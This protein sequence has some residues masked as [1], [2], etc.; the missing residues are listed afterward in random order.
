MSLAAAYLA[1][2]LKDLSRFKEPMNP[3]DM[4]EQEWMRLIRQSGLLSYYE[5]F[6]NAAQ[7]GTDAAFGPAVGT[8][9]D[10]ASLDFGEA[11]EPYTGQYLPVVGPMIKQTAHTA[12]EIVFNFVGE[13]TEK[14]SKEAIDND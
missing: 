9:K 8:A 12:H 1:T 10:I 7:F 5:P 3:I 11:I 13:E 14:A 2:V 6:F 4:T